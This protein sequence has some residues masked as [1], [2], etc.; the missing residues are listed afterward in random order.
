MLN[1]YDVIVPVVERGAIPSA[2]ST[3]V[4][5]QSIARIVSTDHILFVFT[6][7]VIPI[8][9]KPVACVTDQETLTYSNLCDLCKRLAEPALVFHLR[10]L[11]RS[12]FR[13]A[14]VVSRPE[15]LTKTI[16]Q[17]DTYSTTAFTIDHSYN[18]TVCLD[19]R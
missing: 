16:K 9:V 10:E 2:H 14:P 1:G 18:C 11:R 8:L 6:F 3:L 4:R 17:V 12:L 19:L 15:S 5:G 13:L 7:N